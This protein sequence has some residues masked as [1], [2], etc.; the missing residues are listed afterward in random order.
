MDAQK[1]HVPHLHIPFKSWDGDAS[2]RIKSQFVGAIVHGY[3]TYMYMYDAEMSKTDLS[4]SILWATIVQELRRR[5]SLALPL[6]KVLY[7]QADNTKDNKNSALYAFAELL[8]KLRIFDKVKFSFLPV[9]HTHEDID[10]CFGAGSH[11]LHRSSAFCIND[12]FTLWKR[13]WPSTKTFL[14]LKVF[15]IFYTCR[16]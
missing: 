7:V 14:Y 3:G 2:R 12:V 1:C 13:G 15:F 9:G 11:M 5:D 16:T 6:P 4:N 10:A 8:V